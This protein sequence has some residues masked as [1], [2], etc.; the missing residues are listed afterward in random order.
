MLFSCS[1]NTMVIQFL[2]C[3]PKHQK[4]SIIKYICTF[5]IL[6]SNPAGIDNNNLVSVGL[7]H[8][9]PKGIL[10]VGLVSESELFF[11]RQYRVRC[12]SVGESTHGASSGSGE[13]TGN[14][15]KSS[16]HPQGIL[17]SS[18]AM[19]MESHWHRK[20][21]SGLSIFSLSKKWKFCI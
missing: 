17:W 20:M 5:Y 2:F 18:S 10:V 3:V 9:F 12:S 16:G 7:F 1:Y 19:T 14:A 21:K 6:E 11:F 8:S 13:P 4:W 15:S